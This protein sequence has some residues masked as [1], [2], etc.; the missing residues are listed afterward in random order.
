MIHLGTV[1]RC[2][3]RC[4]ARSVGCVDFQIRCGAIRAFLDGCMLPDNPLAV[5]NRHCTFIFICYWTSLELEG[6]KSVYKGV[7]VVRRLLQFEKRVESDED[8]LAVML[9]GSSLRDASPS[10]MDL[11][12][13]MR[14]GDFSRLSL[15]E[16]RLDYLRDF[17]DY[18]VR[19]FQQLPIYIRIRVLK[20][21]KAIFCRDE[22]SLY[23]LAIREI[24][25]FERFRPI[26]EDYLEEVL[27]ARREKDPVKDR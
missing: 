2:N 1:A 21:G 23:D 11:C 16:K 26:Y 3:D 12:M 14:Q 8:I 6:I 9:F 7:V 10:D 25:E 20:E 13:I 4:S 18:D 17:P 19:I 22:D 24:R 27:H 5:P 15:S